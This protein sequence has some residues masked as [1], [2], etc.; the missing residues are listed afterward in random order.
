MIR[1]RIVGKSRGLVFGLMVGRRLRFDDDCM[2]LNR[3]SELMMIRIRIARKSRGLVLGL[4][5]E[6]TLGFDYD[7]LYATEFLCVM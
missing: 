3:G 7:S 1:S 4:L 5:V 6:R 2:P